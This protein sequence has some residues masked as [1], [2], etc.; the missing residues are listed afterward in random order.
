MKKHILIVEDD[1]A[2]N[3]A[4]KMV[5]AKKGY[6]VTCVFNGQEALEVA[7]KKKFDL[8]LLDLLMP[9]MN[10]AD[11]LRNFNAKEKNI[12]VVVFTNIDSQKDIE[13]V[14][15]LGAT[16]SILKAWA[17]PKELLKII[18]DTLSP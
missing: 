11:F 9:V 4:F 10:G 16:R 15:Q 12:P 6:R 5:L 18:N 1:P 14:Q 7:Q 3:D 17:S 8:I 13:E 2:L